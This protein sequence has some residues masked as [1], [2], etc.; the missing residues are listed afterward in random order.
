MGGIAGQEGASGPVA[1]GVAVLEPEVG[2]PDGVVQPAR[3]AEQEIT[4]WL[5]TRGF[6]PLGNWETQRYD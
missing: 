5:I 6:K 3:C 2:Q 1:G 4:G